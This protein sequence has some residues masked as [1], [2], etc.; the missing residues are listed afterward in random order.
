MNRYTRRGD[1]RQSQPVT[2]HQ[3]PA[4]SV[5]ARTSPNLLTVN[6]AA[7]FLATSRWSVYRLVRCGELRAVRVGERLRFKPDDLEA[8]IEREPVP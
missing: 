4:S 2:Q 6:Q 3:H 7:A 1:A 8:Y 5:T